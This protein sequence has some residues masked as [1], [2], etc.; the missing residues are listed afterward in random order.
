MAP[1]EQIMLLM[2]EESAKVLS[3]FLC[4]VLFIYLKWDSAGQTN[5]QIYT[6]CARVSLKDSFHL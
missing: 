1:K 4:P 2:Q 3:C 6:V 5:V